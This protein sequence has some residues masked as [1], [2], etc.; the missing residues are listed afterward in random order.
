MMFLSDGWW[1]VRNFG[2]WCGELAARSWAFEVIVL[3]CWVIWRETDELGWIRFGKHYSS[4]AEIRKRFEIFVENLELIHSTN[5]QGL[6]YKIGINSKICVLYFLLSSIHKQDAQKEKKRN[7]V[8][9]S[10]RAWEFIHR[11]DTD[12]CIHRFGLTKCYWD[13]NRICGFELGGVQGS[14]LGRRAKLFSYEGHPQAHRCHSSWDGISSIH[15]LLS[16]ILF[17]A[18]ARSF[19]H[20]LEYLT[21]SVLMAAN[22]KTG[23]KKV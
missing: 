6:S 22:R 2:S 5:K 17:H 11:K 4:V 3:N 1:K 19:S 12:R 23:G 21:N 15:C 16:K 14:S 18:F 10:F 7:S 20:L 8:V 13:L 9:F